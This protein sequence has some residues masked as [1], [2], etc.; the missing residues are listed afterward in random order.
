MQHDTQLWVRVVFGIND[1]TLDFDSDNELEMILDENDP[2]NQD[3]TIK[4]IDFCKEEEQVDL[5]MVPMLEECITLSRHFRCFKILHG[6]V[7]KK[8]ERLWKILKSVQKRETL[9]E[10]LDKLI[11][12]DLKNIIQKDI[13]FNESDFVHMDHYL[14]IMGPLA[15]QIKKLQGDKNCYNGQLLPSLITIEQFWVKLIENLTDTIDKTDIRK[16]KTGITM[17]RDFIRGMISHLKRRFS[18][19]FSVQGVGEIAAIAIL[20]HPRFK[21][22]WVKGLS[23]EAQDNVERLIQAKNQS[24]EDQV[25]QQVVKDKDFY[26]RANESRQNHFVEDREW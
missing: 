23:R 11:S 18:A 2:T 19:F 6:I 16:D 20:S 14:K 1:D 5:E 7:L 9:V 17:H 4:D 3:I 21:K 24:S 10:Y 25:S 15:D 26:C 22:A 8:C 12:K 13:G